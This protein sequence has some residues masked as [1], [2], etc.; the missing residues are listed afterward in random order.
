MGK[1]FIWHCGKYWDDPGRAQT[2]RG[3]REIQVRGG[4]ESPAAQN[5]QILDGFARYLKSSEQRT[6]RSG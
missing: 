3:A 1:V 2:A 6:G 4:L 5:G